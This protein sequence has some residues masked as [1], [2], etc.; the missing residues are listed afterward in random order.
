MG[1]AYFGSKA[2]AELCHAIIALMPVHSV[3][4][5]SHLGGDAILKRKPAAQRNIGIDADAAAI[6]QLRCDYAVKPVRV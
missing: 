1:N 5:E 3:Y 2:T 6:A 4:L